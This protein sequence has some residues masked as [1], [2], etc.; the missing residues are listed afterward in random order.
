MDTGHRRVLAISTIKKA[1]FQGSHMHGVK[2]GKSAADTIAVEVRPSTA[3]ILYGK[4]LYT[5]LNKMTF[6]RRHYV[7][8]GRQSP[9]LSTD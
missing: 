2:S 3:P 6:Q 4:F 9:Q 7:G 1:A 5:L 8:I